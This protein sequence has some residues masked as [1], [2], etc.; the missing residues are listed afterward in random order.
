MKSD[1]SLNSNEIDVMF[2]LF[3]R[4]ASSA[5]E[6]VAGVT[7]LSSFVAFDNLITKLKRMSFVTVQ[8]DVLYSLSELGKVLI[9]K[10]EPNDYLKKDIERRGL[11]GVSF[12]R[13]TSYVWGSEQENKNT[14]KNPAFSLLEKSTTEEQVVN[15]ANETGDKVDVA[16]KDWLFN[17]SEKQILRGENKNKEGL[18]SLQSRH[19]YVGE[20]MSVIGEKVLSEDS[21]RA[22]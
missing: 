1:V 2:F 9:G 7:S 22:L 15:S 14:D 10:T 20:H 4:P 5:K 21:S 12:K 19:L 18:L 6:V 13:E 16:S 3:D 8:R 17:E 11:T